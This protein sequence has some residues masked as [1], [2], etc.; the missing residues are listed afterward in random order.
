MRDRLKAA[1]R[2]LALTDLTFD[3]SMAELILPLS[4]GATVVISDR[5]NAVA[6]ARTAQATVAQ[7]TPSGWLAFLAAE[8]EDA[9]PPTIWCGGEA[10]PKPLAQRL[11][12]G[13]RD[14]LNLYGPTEATVWASVSEVREDAGI[15]LGSPLRGYTYRVLDEGGDPVADGERGLLHIGGAMLADGYHGRPAE[16]AK[17]FRPDS[18][19]FLP[20][21]RM[22]NTGDWVRGVAGGELVFLGRA[23]FQLKIRGYRV[24]PEEI[25]AVLLECPGILEAAVSDRPTLAAFVV[26]RGDAPD[27]SQIVAFLRN[28][29]PAYM[30]PARVVLVPALPHNANGKLDRGK[31]PELDNP[32]R[33]RARILNAIARIEEMSDHEVAALLGETR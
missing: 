7:S 16:T 4:I 23:D 9:R 26:A 8:G 30:V 12:S 2:M 3:I 1:D 5:S 24:E 13:G 18:E 6:N 31:L 29:L 33:S 15:T 17:R 22:Y 21:Q 32:S 19:S 28:R 10:L 25:E 14:V 27:A 20:G 11:M